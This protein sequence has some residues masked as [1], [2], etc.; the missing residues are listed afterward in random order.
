MLFFQIN[1]SRYRALSF[2]QI[3]KKRKYHKIQNKC[4][5]HSPV[6]NISPRTC[7]GG[8][9]LMIRRINIGSLHEKYLRRRAVEVDGG[10]PDGAVRLKATVKTTPIQTNREDPM[11]V[12]WVRIRSGSLLWLFSKNR[13]CPNDY[14]RDCTGSNRRG[15]RDW[16]WFL[17]SAS[18]SVNSLWPPWNLGIATF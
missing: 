14:R 18:I 12:S 11:T 15:I 8:W 13:D 10:E 7:K 5:N 1:S 3:E 16:L 9:K 6:S 17:L 4:S 2:S